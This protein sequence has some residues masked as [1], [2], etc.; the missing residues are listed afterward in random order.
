MKRAVTLASLAQI[1]LLSFLSALRAAAT[2][3][4]ASQGIRVNMTLIFSAPQALLAANAVTRYISPFVGR[5]DDISEDG[6]Q[7]LGTVVRR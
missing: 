5:F 3:Q 7:Q 1:L 4:L 6:M 2:H